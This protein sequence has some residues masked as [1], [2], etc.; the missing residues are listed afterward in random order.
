MVNL[1]G[2]GKG[3]VLSGV[4]EALRQ[5]GLA[6]HL[7]GKTRAAAG[8]KMGHFTVIADSMEEALARAEAARRSLRWG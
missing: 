8:R 6:L 3:D 4:E 7:Y 1:V 2:D 5:E